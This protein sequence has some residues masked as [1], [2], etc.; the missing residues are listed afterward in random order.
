MGQW[1]SSVP[2]SLRSRPDAALTAN[3]PFVGGAEHRGE[4][5]P[6]GFCPA[7]AFRLRPLPFPIFTPHMR[8]T[9]AAEVFHSQSGPSSQTAPET[10]SQPRKPRRSFP[11]PPAGRPWRGL[12]P[13]FLLRE[14]TAP[15]SPSDRSPLPSRRVGKSCVGVRDHPHGFRPAGPRLQPNGCASARRIISRPREISGSES[16]ARRRAEGPRRCLPDRLALPFGK[17]P[18]GING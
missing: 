2:S 9:P 11:A 18:S 5:R 10:I 17:H 12:A 3:A 13:L 4:L 14:K 1:R 15:P 6:P 16:L 8:R 7:G